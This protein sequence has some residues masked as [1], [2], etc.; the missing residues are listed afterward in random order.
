MKRANNARTRASTLTANPRR[1]P[2]LPDGQQPNVGNHEHTPGTLTNS[3]GTY[4]VDYAA[5]MARYAAVPKTGNGNLW[6]SFENGPVHY[7]FIDS[8]EAQ[9]AGSP[10]LD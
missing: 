4:N 5:Y 3:S 8:E 2:L 7:T 10:Q 9:S 6:Y 1:R